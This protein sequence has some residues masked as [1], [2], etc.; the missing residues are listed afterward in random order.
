MRRDEVST[1]FDAHEKE[2][3]APEDR[4]DR[5]VSEKVK[6]I[7]QVEAEQTNRVAE[8]RAEKWIGRKYVGYGGWGGQDDEYDVEC[9][10]VEAELDIASA[11]P[12]RA[13]ARRLLGGHTFT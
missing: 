5:K 9:D 13:R 3:L 2:E 6:R 7:V 1:F 4:V 8:P 11:P 12:H 10:R